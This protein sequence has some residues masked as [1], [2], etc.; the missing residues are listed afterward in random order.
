MAEIEAAHPELAT[1]DS[2]TRQ[3]GAAR[4]VAVAHA[5][6]AGAIESESERA[7]SVGASPRVATT[8]FDGFSYVAL[9]HLHRPQQVADHVRYS[10]SPVAM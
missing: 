8:T 4:S 6:V 1:D 5:F 3:V 9:G 10:G 2:P 7:L